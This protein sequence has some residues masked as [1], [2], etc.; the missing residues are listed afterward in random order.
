MKKQIAIS[1]IGA[2]FLT[3]GAAL[4]TGAEWRDQQAPY[5][6]VFGNHLDTHQQTKVMPD[7]ELKGF[8]YIEFTGEYTADGY[9][10]AQHTDCFDEL[11]D[12]TV[13]W[14]LKGVPGHASFVYHESGDHPLWQVH[15]RD[16]IPQPGG[17]SHFHWLDGPA[18]AG[19]LMEGMMYHGYFLE[20]TAKDTFVFRHGS[21]EI[22][23][24]PGLD[25]AT[26]L[27]L[28]SAFPG[29]TDPG[30]GGDDGHTH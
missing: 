18:M 24:T 22:L 9:P 11:A 17:Y 27:N 20:L 29:T 3:A 15:S 28:V 13:G 5:D 10:I 2:F 6:F 26:H 19:D 21:E 25:L 8:L 1:V 23:V 16:D 30:G 12:C 7:G 4:A 14:S